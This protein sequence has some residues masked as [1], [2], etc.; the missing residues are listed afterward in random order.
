MSLTHL[1]APTLA[2]QAYEAVRQA[3]VDG[4]LA[5]GEKVTE[6]GLAD[7]LNTSPTPVREA[8]RRLEQD[9][10]LER[11]GLRTLVVTA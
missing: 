1:S 6:R 11:R 3:I 4:S 2:V 8:I 7:L 10:L 5:R 9:R